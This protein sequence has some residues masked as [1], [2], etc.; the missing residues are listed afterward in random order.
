M[1]NQSM[2]GYNEAKDRFDALLN[3]VLTII[4]K[5]AEGEDPDTADLTPSCTGSCSTCGGCG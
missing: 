3:R 5:S 4:R 1:S 2:I